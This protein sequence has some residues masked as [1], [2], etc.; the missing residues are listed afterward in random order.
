MKKEDVSH[1]QNKLKSLIASDDEIILLLRDYDDLFSDF[2]PRNYGQRALSQDFLIELKRAAFDKPDA[3]QLKLIVP[4][5]KRDKETENLIRMRLH[6]HFRKHHELL[7]QE[8]IAIKKKGFFMT[9][10]GM[11]MLVLAAI[12]SFLFSKSH[13]F[14]VSLLL[15]LLEPAGWFT[16]WTG[17]DQFYYTAK[18]KQPDLDFY[19]KMVRSAIIFVPY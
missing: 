8:M 14:L 7:V 5:S 3:V 18:L 15:V 6:N 1:I 10:G 16:A 9:T 19:H 11:F 2:D 13:S 17:L 4:N 12:I